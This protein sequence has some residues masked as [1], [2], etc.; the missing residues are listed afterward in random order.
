MLKC[1][2]KERLDPFN[3]SIHMCVYDYR[4][5]TNNYEEVYTI[6][7]NNV[8]LR[9][10]LLRSDENISYHFYTKHDL[11]TSLYISCNMFYG[12]NVYDVIQDCSSDADYKTLT[13][14]YIEVTRDQLISS[15]ISFDLFKN[16]VDYFMYETIGE[17]GDNIISLVPHGDI[18]KL[19]FR[20]EYMM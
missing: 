17:Y 1:I 6:L 7:Y 20:S 19:N 3:K 18:F 11:H 12:F 15:N 5:Y 9:D 14:D 4:V 16:I 2:K 10:K 8:E 13:T